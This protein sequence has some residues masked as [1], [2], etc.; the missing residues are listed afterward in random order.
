M[1]N[2]V[3]TWR[4][5]ALAWHADQL[6]HMNMRYYFDRVLEARARFAH[7]LGLPHIYKLESLSTLL[8]VA[9]HINYI[10]EIRPAEALVVSSGVLNITKTDRPVR[11]VHSGRNAQKTKTG[12]LLN[13]LFSKKLWKKIKKEWKKIPNTTGLGNRSQNTSSGP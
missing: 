8:P 13:G 4:G 5:E 7:H 6:G 12:V 2:L 11:I 1:D 3:E 9:Q 10:K